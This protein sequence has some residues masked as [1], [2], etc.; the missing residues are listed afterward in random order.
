LKCQAVN[1]VTLTSHFLCVVS[2]LVF[3]GATE[4]TTDVE[5]ESPGAAGGADAAPEA[6]RE[7][8]ELRFCPVL[9]AELFGGGP[10]DRRVST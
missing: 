10:V 2:E 6:G 7:N 5:P 3:S 8:R 4:C 9:P 1:S